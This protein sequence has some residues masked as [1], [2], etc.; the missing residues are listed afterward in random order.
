MAKNIEVVLKL[1]NQTFNRNIKT[2]GQAVN[3]FSKE[4]ES[5]FNNVRNAFI[6]LAGALSIREIVSLS[7]EFTNLNNRLVAVTGSQEV[8]ADALKL[9]R[10]VAADSRSDLG[11]VASLFADLTVATRDLGTEQSTIADVTRVFSQTLQ[12]SGADAGAAAGAIRQF[13]QALA[14]GTLRGD[15]FNSIAE[16]NS[17]FMLQ[18]AESLGKPLG[19]LRELARQGKLTAEVVLAATLDMKDRVEADFSNTATTVGQAFTSLRNSV[20]GLFGQIEGE[21]GVFESLAGSIQDLATSINNVDVEGLIATLQDLTR[22]AGLLALAFGGSAVI[23]LFSKFQSVMIGIGMSLGGLRKIMFPMTAI[24]N[25]LSR[26]FGN[27]TRVFTGA[28]KGGRIGALGGVFANL[29]KALIRFLGPVGLVIGSLE[30]ISFISKKLGGPDFMKGFRDFVSDGVSDLMGFNKEIEQAQNNLDNFVGPP[31]PPGFG[32]D[33]G[34]DGGGPSVVIPE[35]ELS[36]VQAFEQSL[37]GLKVTQ[38]NYKASLARLNAEFSTDTVGDLQEYNQAL[39]AIESAFPEQVE[40]IREL[41][42]EQERQKENQEELAEKLAQG[43]EAIDNFNEGFTEEIKLTADLSEKQAELNA[44]LSKYPELADA[45]AEAQDRLNEAL[46]DNEAL[47]SFL[48]TLGTAQKALS[49][50]LATA[51]VEGKSAAEA[52]QS[53]FKKLV[54]QLIADALRLAIIQPILGSLFGVSFGAGGA[55]SGLTGGGLLGF[56]G[57]KANGGPVMKNKPYIVGERGP[58]LFVPGQSGGI[59][60]NEALGMGGG[61]TVNYNIQAVDAQ[62]FQQLVA[63]D[64]EFIF[65]V[66]EAGRRRLPQ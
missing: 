63:R 16:S 41:L 54:V 10:Q 60:P 57:G 48:N 5:G 20:L 42:K 51:L 4:S 31:L 38:D 66:T 11:S 59:V 33:G 39:R 50:D 9:V 2:S 43:K 58:E 62:S 35:K 14:S 24:S 36:K 19:E 3:K 26:A 7:D 23:R 40:A 22:I 27:L 37:K 28:A 6:G 53:F 47:N 45:I 46:S 15:E 44:L 30:G 34:D 1:D 49:E 61:T 65:A 12:I 29:G 18:L 17:F 32:D 64:P 21:T 8:A 55:I 52:F 25:N 13:G 56:I